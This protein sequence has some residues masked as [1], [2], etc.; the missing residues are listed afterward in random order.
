MSLSY[1]WHDYTFIFYCLGFQL[2]VTISTS[3]GLSSR[4][5][6]WQKPLHFASKM[7]TNC[8]TTVALLKRLIP[9]S[10]LICFA[11]V[12]QDAC[13]V[14]SVI[15]LGEN[16]NKKWRQKRESKGTPHYISQHTTQDVLP[17]RIGDRKIAV[18]AHKPKSHQ[19]GVQTHRDSRRVCMTPGYRELP[20]LLQHRGHVRGDVSRSHQEICGR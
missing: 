6:C 2:L 3:K 17:Q 4:V 10:L 8:E 7:L 14:I 13:I 11:A 1:G 12:F 9:L 19:R 16:D 5:K 15:C 18:Q 20:L